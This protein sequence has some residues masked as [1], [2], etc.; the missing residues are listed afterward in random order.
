[1]SAST[2]DAAMLRPGLTDAAPCASAFACPLTRAPHV[3]AAGSAACHR[4]LGAHLG[5]HPVG[6]AHHV[7]VQLAPVLLELAQF[8]CDAK[9]CKLDQALGIVCKRAHAC[10]NVQA[11]CNQSARPCGGAT[12]V[13]LHLYFAGSGT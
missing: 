11:A 7:L 13:A 8:G 12:G 1:V 9:V 6:R 4:R 2:R 5:R 10:M 3:A